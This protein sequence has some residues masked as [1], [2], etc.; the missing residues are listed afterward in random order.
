MYS[1]VQK[2]KK[3]ALKSFY[4]DAHNHQ[5]L[6]NLSPPSSSRWKGVTIFSPLECPT[7]HFPAKE[8]REAKYNARTRYFMSAM[9]VKIAPIWFLQYDA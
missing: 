2:N 6:K 1:K 3:T 7:P 8:K 4:G 5:K 9:K